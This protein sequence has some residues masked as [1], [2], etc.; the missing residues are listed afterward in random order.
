M[1]PDDSLL[2]VAAK[3]PVKTESMLIENLQMASA[4]CEA[5]K[6]VQV[7]HLVYISSDAVYADSRGLLN[8]KSCVQPGS[9]HGG[10]HLAREVMAA[11]ARQGP[12]C[13]LPLL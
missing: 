13:Y 11:N 8:E 12:L 6:K 1:K 9:L 4:V 7:Q 2:F 3:V 10:M 5:L